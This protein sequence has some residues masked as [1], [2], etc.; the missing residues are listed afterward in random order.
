MAKNSNKNSCKKERR[1]ARNSWAMEGTCAQK[2]SLCCG[3][4]LDYNHYYYYR[5]VIIDSDHLC[6]AAKS[7]CHRLIVVCRDKDAMF[8][9]PRSVQVQR[10]KTATAKTRVNLSR[11]RGGKK[12]GSKAAASDEH[13]LRTRNLRDIECR[14]V[15]ETRCRTHMNTNEKSNARLDIQSLIQD[16]YGLCD[17]IYSLSHKGDKL[18]SFTYNIVLHGFNILLEVNVSYFYIKCFFF[19]FSIT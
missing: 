7:A 2:G 6:T 12:S 9:D 4:C 11:Q 5:K 3:Y 8:V 1:Q 18:P 15:P 14:N 13:A 17:S 19:V 16:H 10:A